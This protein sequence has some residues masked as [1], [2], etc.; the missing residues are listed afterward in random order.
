[1]W[2]NMWSII[3]QI[4]LHYGERGNRQRAIELTRSL[5]NWTRGKYAECGITHNI[6]VIYERGIRTHNIC[7]S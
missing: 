6:T 2:R 1:M 7:V 5:A 4:S 3:I